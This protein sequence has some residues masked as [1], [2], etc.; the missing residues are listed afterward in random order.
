MTRK[1]GLHKKVSSIFGDMPIPGN[2]PAGYGNSSPGAPLPGIDNRQAMNRPTPVTSLRRTEE[3]EYAAS[4]RKKLF[5][6]IALA[7]ILGV[8]LFLNFYKPG[9]TATQNIPTPQKTT[10]VALNDL[11][12]SWPDPGTWSSDIKDPM[13]INSI[14]TL[15]NIKNEGTLT[16]RGIVG[17]SMA[18]IGTEILNKGDQ[19]QGWTVKEIFKDSVLLEKPDGE[20]LELK[21]ENR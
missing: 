13:I 14:V 19:Y 17:E 2:P 9:K 3:Q 10:A 8:V 20:K 6:G 15:N 1:S 21:M 4:Q 5:A 11:E 16:L 12:I 18:L 7:C